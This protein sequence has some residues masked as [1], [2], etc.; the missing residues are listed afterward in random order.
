MKIWLLFE[1]GL[2]CYKP[3]VSKKYKRKLVWRVLITDSFFFHR[4]MNGSLSLCPLPLPSLSLC[5]S[6][7]FCLWLCVCW[8]VWTCVCVLVGS[9]QSTA[10]ASV[11][12]A[13]A[14]VAAAAGTTAGLVEQGSAALQ[15]QFLCP[16]LSGHS[17]LHIP[18]IPSFVPISIF[19]LLCFP[20]KF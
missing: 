11:T 7:S 19:H 13:V 10:P 12:V 5:S 4:L 15:A 6:L 14:A 1:W 16:F 17:S 2:F 9:R 8:W 3:P 20:L 18:P